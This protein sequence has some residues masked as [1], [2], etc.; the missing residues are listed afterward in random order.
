MKSKNFEFLRERR[1]ELATLGAFAERYAAS[2]PPSALVKMRTFVEQIVEDIYDAKHLPKPF[3]SGL[4]DLL[5]E[6]VFTEIVPQVVIQKI[7]ALRIRGNKAAHGENMLA[8]IAVPLVKEAFDIGCWFHVT[9]DGG[10]LDDIP[11]F[12]VDTTSTTEESKGRLKREKKELL[13]KLARQEAQLAQ[14]LSNLEQE[15]KDREQ[16]EQASASE[17]QNVRQAGESAVSELHFSEAQTR[18][19]LIDSML[20]ESGWDVGADGKDT[21][22]VGQET[23][24][25]GLPT[26]SGD[27]Y[28]DYVLWGDDGKPTAVVEAKKTAK[29]AEIGRTQAQQYADSLETQY[30]QRPVVFYSNGV[31]TFI[32]DDAQGFPPR[33]IYGF[34]SKDSLE[35]LLFQR[36]NKEQIELVAPKNEI[37]GRMY[38]LEAVKRVT[39]RFSEGHRKALLVQA[40]GTGK[41][42]VA[43][44]ICD[45]MSRAKWA[46]RILFLCD[47]RELRKQADN[48]FKEFLPTEPRVFVSSKTASDRDKRI[49]LAT[50]PA[51]MKCFESFDV[52]FF[53]LVIADESHRSI[54]NK[55]RDLFRYFDACQVGLTA[56]PVRLL[57]RNTYG[58]FGCED[59][60]PT[61]NYTLEEAINHT[62]RY[63]VPF[64]VVK[65]T[66]KFQR[67]GIK[68]S[69]MTDEEKQQLEDQIDDAESIEHE[70]TDINRLIFNRDTSRSILR[71]VMQN[72]IRDA[73]GSLPGKTII[74]ARN[75]KHAEYLADVFAE[76]YPKYGGNFCRVIDNYDPRAEQLID[77]FKDPSHELRIAIS[78]DMLD[79]GI[80]VPEIVNL[81]FAKPIKSYVKFWQMIG[82]GTRL[83]L[84]L[85]GPNQHKTEFL[86]FDH[87]GNFEY[88]DEHYEETQPNPT[89]SLMQRVFEARVELARIAM[90]KM[91]EESFQE[92]IKL[93]QADINHVKASKAIEVRDHWRDLQTLGDEATLKSFAAATHAALIDVVAPLMRWCDLRGHEDAYR[94]DFK[95]AQM[96]TALLQESGEFDDLKGQILADV[97]ALRK[98]LNQVKAKAE[99]IKKVQST[100]FWDDVSVA[101]L[102]ELRA[103]LRAIMKHKV[104]VRPP[105]LDPRMIDVKDREIE[106]E[107]HV[108]TFDGHELIAYRHRVQSILEEHFN[109]HPTLAL[110]RSG[111]AVSEKDL[112]ALA[113][114]VLKID[115]QIDLKHLPIQINIKGDLHKALRSIVGLDAEAVASAFTEFTHKHMELTSQQLRFLS[116]LQA[117]IC[118]NGGLEIDRLYE[119]PF[120]NVSAEGIDGV[121]NDTLTNELLE[122]I[123]RFNLPEIQGAI[124]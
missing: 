23:P 72:G 111:K 14:L 37:A 77:D 38:Q 73:S 60:D 50:Y 11:T 26:A 94:F 79:T 118:A 105:R 46:K 115:P 51:M 104:I 116:M 62:P 45:V 12:K 16:L 64:R 121:F 21:S 87:W 67:E 35:Y 99:S 4:H 98:N 29:S 31:D 58:L 123:A 36:N 25:K 84:H 122:L 33:K 89:K 90:E 44:S 34:Y 93:I 42:R 100:K 68:Y 107:D 71:N 43:I 97:D 56:T 109:S 15:R 70:A 83:R 74:F 52:G 119:A 54:Y 108:P 88:F 57:D 117:H 80:D 9:F 81:V 65:I 69:K 7:H 103:D 95:V 124:A 22:E 41:T 113:H 112:E 76:L 49:Y 24:L 106:T 6:P 2:D 66:T 63:L 110:I 101:S 47:R 78:V 82:R 28:A 55:Y 32:W 19:F 53:D 91:E 61:S 10:K 1:A 39:E 40:T 92:S 75:H 59:K 114:Q 3:R 30:G 27:G 18:K 102:G 85:F 96:Q 86:I 13:Q 120:T 8:T 48:A 20:V 5:N 17:L